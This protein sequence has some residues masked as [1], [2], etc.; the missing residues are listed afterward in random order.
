MDFWWRN[1]LRERNIVLTQHW[2]DIWYSWILAKC[3][4]LTVHSDKWPPPLTQHDG[5]HVLDDDLP[6]HGGGAV[7][8]DVLHALPVL[9]LELPDEVQRVLSCLYLSRSL[10]RER[11]WTKCILPDESFNFFSDDKSD[12][13]NIILTFIGVHRN[14]SELWNLNNVAGNYF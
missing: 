11:G 5:L 2:S 10:N 7:Q 14:V 13:F 1:L 9:G 3:H 8:H 4:P 6:G 12:K